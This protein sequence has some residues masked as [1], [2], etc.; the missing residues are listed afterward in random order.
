MEGDDDCPG[1]IKSTLVGVSLNIP[2]KNGRLALGTWQGIYL[3]EVSRS[4]RLVE[5]HE[6]DG[7]CPPSFCLSASLTLLLSPIC[8]CFSIGTKA[9]GVADTNATL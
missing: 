4:V 7:S 2:I 6:T 9:A 8:S 1:H 3:N 5:L